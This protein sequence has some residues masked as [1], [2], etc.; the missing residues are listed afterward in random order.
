MNFKQFFTESKDIKGWC[1]IED[2]TEKDMFDLEVIKV[3]SII[4]HWR[5]GGETHY[6]LTLDK[7]GEYEMYD[8]EGNDLLPNSFDKQPYIN[9]VKKRVQKHEMI[10]QG[11]SDEQANTAINI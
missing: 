9:A 7:N 10:K 1:E 4:R 11:L 5:H 6:F 2:I 3:W 8:H